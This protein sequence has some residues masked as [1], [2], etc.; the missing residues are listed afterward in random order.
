[1]YGG[2]Y[3]G[4]VGSGDPGGVAGSGAEGLKR[5]V[6]SSSAIAGA[7][8]MPQFRQKRSVPITSLEHERQ[9]AIKPPK[10]IYPNVMS[11]FPITNRTS[12]LFASDK[13]TWIA[14]N[15]L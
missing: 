13:N 12:Q 10:G 9:I 5:R 8:A 7:T 4:L 1:M 15:G 6:S 11:F 2:A 3:K 14:A